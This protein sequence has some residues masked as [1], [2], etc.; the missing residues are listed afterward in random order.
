MTVQTKLWIQGGKNTS[1]QTVITVICIIGNG[2]WGFNLSLGSYP[3]HLARLKQTHKQD[4][5]RLT[6]TNWQQRSLNSCVKLGSVT[7]FKYNLSVVTAFSVCL[8]KGR[9]RRE[10]RSRHKDREKWSRGRNWMIWMQT[11]EDWKSKILM[12][13]K[14]GSKE[15]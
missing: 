9:K 3:A 1:K 4:P 11:K 10:D 15:E 5:Q 6:D 7:S 2:I 13:D 14:D 12:N 8:K